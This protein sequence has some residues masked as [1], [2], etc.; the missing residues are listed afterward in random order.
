VPSHRSVN[1]N[2]G[3]SLCA[4]HYL[5]SIHLG[6]LAK[7]LSKLSVH[8]C[9]NWNRSFL[10]PGTIV[11]FTSIGVDKTMDESTFFRDVTRC[12]RI[13]GCWKVDELTFRQN[14]AHSVTKSK[15]SSI[16]R[17]SGHQNPGPPPTG[18]GGS[19]RS[20]MIVHIQGR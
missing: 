16:L 18:K 8:S 4:F 7:T 13:Y 11:C 3:S 15:V 14:V 2:F 6:F 5:M 19:I 9:S 20:G 10:F 12:Q 17:P 1:V